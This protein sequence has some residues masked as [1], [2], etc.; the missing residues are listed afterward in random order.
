M[1]ATLSA[2]RMPMTMPSTVKALRNLFDR[3][4]SNAIPSTS[5]VI[6]PG[7]RNFM[8]NSW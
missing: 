7:S 8:F 2:V 6:S 4:L 1:A 5:F 3:M